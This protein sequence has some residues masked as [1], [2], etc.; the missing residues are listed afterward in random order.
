[1]TNQTKALLSQIL[2]ELKPTTLAAIVAD[3]SDHDAPPYDLWDFYE[4]TDA[5]LTANLG[6]GQDYDV[7]ITKAVAYVG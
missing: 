3:I 6:D 5:V 1:M 2:S 7:A 4:L